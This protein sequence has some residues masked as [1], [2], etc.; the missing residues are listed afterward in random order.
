MRQFSLYVSSN[1]GRIKKSVYAGTQVLLIYLIILD[2]NLIAV[3]TI[4]N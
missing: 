2:F 4:I 1:K 3:S